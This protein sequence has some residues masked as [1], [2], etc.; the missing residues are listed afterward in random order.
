MTQPSLSASGELPGVRSAITA[1]L[2]KLVGQHCTGAQRLEILRKLGAWADANPG[3]ARHDVLLVVNAVQA[4]AGAV[5]VAIRGRPRTANILDLFGLTPESG[6]TPGGARVDNP[7]N[8]SATSPGVL[9]DHTPASVPAVPKAAPAAPR[10]APPSAPPLA[11]TAPPSDIETVYDPGEGPGGEVKLGTIDRPIDH[12]G[13]R[14]SLRKI[15][16]FESL[17]D[18]RAAFL[19]EYAKCSEHPFVRY[20]RVLD[21]R[22]LFVFVG[23]CRGPATNPSLGDRT[24][25]VCFQI[26]GKSPQAHGALAESREHK[27]GMVSWMHAFPWEDGESMRFWINAALPGQRGSDISKSRVVLDARGFKFTPAQ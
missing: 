27:G 21:G 16:E 20:A 11:K 2:A 6:L 5:P 3:I 14:V 4:G 8:V 23:T 15:P 12:P 22:K 9:L 19:D 17:A 26:R 13:G 1:E 25:N 7:R 18:A 10:A 24:I